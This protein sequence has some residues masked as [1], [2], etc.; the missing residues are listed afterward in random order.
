M[1]WSQLASDKF[2]I[3]TGSAMRTRDMHW[4]QRIADGMLDGEPISNVL[5]HDVTDHF[6]CLG[7]FGPNSRTLL[8]GLTDE[9]LK[10]G[11]CLPAASHPIP[12]AAAAAIQCHDPPLLFAYFHPCKTNARCNEQRC[13]EKSYMLTH[14][15]RGLSVR[16]RQDCGALRSIGGCSC[17]VHPPD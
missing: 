2:M 16:Y 3:V 13:G 11:V 10:T 14:F 15:C 9:S 17:R 1:R 7:V 5:I 6:S 4:L 8:E 12:Q